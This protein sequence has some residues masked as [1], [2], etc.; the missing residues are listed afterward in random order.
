MDLELGLGLGLGTGTLVVRSVQRRALYL[1]VRRAESQINF[2]FCSQLI[3]VWINSNLFLIAAR[4]TGTGLVRNRARGNGTKRNVSKMCNY[5]GAALVFDFWFSIS[6][7]GHKISARSM[8]TLTAAELFLSAAAAL[9]PLSVC[10]LSWCLRPR[11]RPSVHLLFK[12]A[13]FF[14]N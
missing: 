5:L 3:C 8:G 13:Y 2:G 6:G 1:V 12:W 11:P 9:S 10:G 7:H 14:C 4:G